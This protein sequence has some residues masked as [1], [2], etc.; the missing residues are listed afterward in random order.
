MHPL[1]EEIC[2]AREVQPHAFGRW[3]R[4]LRDV[5]QPMLDERDRLLA[6]R[7]ATKAAAGESPRRAR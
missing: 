2:R 1:I 5:I 7:E 6:E 3:Q 4:E